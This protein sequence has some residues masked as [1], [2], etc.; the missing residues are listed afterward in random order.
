MMFKS[1]TGPKCDTNPLL[2]TLDRL[3]IVRVSWEILKQPSEFGSL[4]GETG[5]FGLV[6]WQFLTIKYTM[7]SVQ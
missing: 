6:Q 3:R 4:V 7:Y 1:L 2:F 5:W